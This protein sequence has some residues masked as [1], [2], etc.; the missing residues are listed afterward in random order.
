M[1]VQFELSIA[2]GGDHGVEGEMNA[3]AHARLEGGRHTGFV[4]LEIA[5]KHYELYAEEMLEMLAAL[6][7]LR[8]ARG[9]PQ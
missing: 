2:N 9:V 1:K 6:G 5:G 8:P 4:T 7:Y 3:V